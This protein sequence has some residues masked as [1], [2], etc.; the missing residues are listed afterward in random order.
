MCL[1]LFTLFFISCKL[2]RVIT[3][4]DGKICITVFIYAIT[5]VGSPPLCVISNTTWKLSS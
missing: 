4:A 2:C 5:N 3:W 1:S